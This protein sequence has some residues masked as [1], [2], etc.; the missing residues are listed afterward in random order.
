MKMPKSRDAQ[1]VDRAG[2]NSTGG[3]NY[4]V[5]AK[6]AEGTE[7]CCRPSST[8][9]AVCARLV[10]EEELGLSGSYSDCLNKWGAR[11]CKERPNCNC[12]S[13]FS[14]IITLE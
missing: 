13:G 5:S 14:V 11:S 1:R 10:G 7:F 9:I 8:T 12:S 6:Y 3:L 2:K 4:E